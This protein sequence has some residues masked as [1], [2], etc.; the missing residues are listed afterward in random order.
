VA[1]R[2]G[3]DPAQRDAVTLDEHR[4]FHA[5]LAPVDRGRAGDLAATRRLGDASVDCDLVED[6]S[7]DAVVVLAGDAGQRGELVPQGAGKPIWRSGHAASTRSRS[8]SNFMIG[9]SVPAPLLPRH[10]ATAT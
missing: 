8:V 5:L 10:T 1:L 6:Q 7:D 9:R 3:P 4:P 2:T